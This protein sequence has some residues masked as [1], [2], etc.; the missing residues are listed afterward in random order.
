VK[1][2]ADASV[3]IKWFV[4]E[5]HW[6]AASRLLDGETV[7]CAPDLIGP[8]M[9]N[10]L[11][12]KIRRGEVGAAKA[13]EMLGIFRTLGV[14]I[15]PSAVLLPSALDLAVRLDNTLY[16]CVYLA[17]ALAQ[18]CAL[19]TADRKFHRAVVASAHAAHTRWVED[20]G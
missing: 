3:A 2:V 5:V 20:E 16:D 17:L 15:Y 18:N 9:G 10:I 6:A 12:K 19:V 13:F 4:P 8:E 11:W 14:E 7:I 1:L